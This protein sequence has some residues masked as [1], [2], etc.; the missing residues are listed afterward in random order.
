M[1]Y[2]TNAL[3][4]KMLFRPYKPKWYTL[5]WQGIIPRTRTILASSVAKVVGEKLVTAEEIDKSLK[6]EGIDKRLENII[7]NYITASDDRLLLLTDRVVKFALNKIQTDPSLA[8]AIDNKTAEIAHKLLDTAL[9]VP[10]NFAAGQLYLA[11]GR[12]KDNDYYFKEVILNNLKIAADKYVNTNKSL[13]EIVPSIDTGKIA[14][15]IMKEI[16]PAIT[17]LF[18]SPMFIES[19]EKLLIK[20]KQE[21]SDKSSLTVKMMASFLKDDK[22]KEMTRENLPSLGR[23]IT[24]D[25]S[26]QYQISVTIVKKLDEILN[27]PLKELIM[28]LGG[29]KYNTLRDSLLNKLVDMFLPSEVL[30]KIAQT[31]ENKSNST[32]T[33]A[34]ALA[35]HGIQ[36]W[37]IIPESLPVSEFITNQTA[38]DK[39]KE[40]VEYSHK[41]LTRDKSAQNVSKLLANVTLKSLETVIPLFLNFIDIKSLVEQKINSLEMEGVEDLLFSFMKNHFKWINILGFI[42]GFLVG[43]VQVFVMLARNAAV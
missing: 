25:K 26:I 21:Y 1:G 24:E 6:C 34:D 13:A 2:L 14:L 27:R 11:S 8:K 37:N 9:S 43:V 29:K 12:L 41:K 30:L 42:I 22:I 18:S 35:E 3:A 38:A 7:Y 33:I 36:V 4:I 39:I 32:Q 5:G 28:E 15:L 20:Q 16:N 19:A 17:E 10:V 31:L 40:L 23:K